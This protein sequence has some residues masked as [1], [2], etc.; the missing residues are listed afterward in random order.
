VARI[1][2]KEVVL[3][4]TFVTQV[5]LAVALI[6]TY[7]DEHPIGRTRVLLREL[8]QEGIRNPSGYFLF[9][10]LPDGSYTLGVESEHYQD[11]EL[12]INIPTSPPGN[13]LVDI[14][15]QPRPSYPFPSGATLIRGLVRDAPGNPIIEARAEVVG[16]NIISRSGNKGEFVLFFGGLKEGDIVK[17]NS[18]RFIRGNGTKVITLKVDQP[19]YGSK[20]TQIME[21]VEEGKTTSVLITF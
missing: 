18:K 15:L 8:S 10:N 12:V 3:D 20:T 4:E 21:G 13:P 14:V 5:S 1:N 9:L 7:T 6:D 2:G 17:E 19:A 16:K 11:E